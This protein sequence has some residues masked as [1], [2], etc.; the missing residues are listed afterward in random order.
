MLNIRVWT[1]CLF[2]SLVGLFCFAALPVM[3]QQGPLTITD[4]LDAGL[5]AA[6][7]AGEITELNLS[8]SSGDYT[9]TLDWAYADANRLTVVY[10]IDGRPGVE[11]TNLMTAPD[12]SV[13]DENGAPVI[14]G[15]GMSANMPDPETSSALVLTTGGFE[16]EPG[17]TLTVHMD[18]VIVQAVTAEQRTAVPDPERFDEL[19]ERSEPLSFAFEV[20]VSG[21]LREQTEAQTVTDQDIA[22]TLE[23][24]RVSPTYVRLTVCFDEPEAERTWTSI[25]FV[26]VGGDELVPNGGTVNYV[27]GAR[28]AAYQRPRTGESD[29]TPEATAAPTVPARTCDDHR[30]IAATE[31]YA[32]ITDWTV[33]VRELVGFGSSGA[34]QNRIAGNW[35]FEVELPE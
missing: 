33:D 7:K 2:V 19:I 8:E 31:P 16:A 30:Y 24:I 25:P 10:H 15:A 22:L 13:T 12:I 29:A 17:T 11:Y 32:G 26:L 21:T 1:R 34:D 5:A 14:G 35:A 27:A 28:E 23:S 6:Y 20:P 9:V 18:N 3:A 4:L